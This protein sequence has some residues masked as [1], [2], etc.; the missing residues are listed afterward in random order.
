MY[1]LTGEKDREFLL[2]MATRVQHLIRQQKGDIELAR[3]FGDA[4]T[5]RTRSEAI[6]RVA[7]ELCAEVRQVAAALGDALGED[8]PRALGDR[9]GA[10]RTELET[11]LRPEVDAALEEASG[12][13]AGEALD[14][15][16]TRLDEAGARLLD[17]WVGRRTDEVRLVALDL[18]A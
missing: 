5:D 15:A 17:E 9:S 1:F 13:V 4:G 16:R 2:R 3:L 12:G 10:W 8:L 6:D 18:A 7:D 14:Q 11:L